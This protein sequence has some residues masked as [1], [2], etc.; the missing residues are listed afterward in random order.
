MKLSVRLAAGIALCAALA[1]VASCAKAPAGKW[2][3]GSWQ[4]KGEGL[5]GDIDVT[6]TVTGGRIASVTIDKQE[7]A[8]GVSD[9][10]L[11]RIPEEIVKAQSTKVDTV[12]GASMSS[13][14][15]IAAVEDALTKAVKQ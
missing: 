3:D 12:A 10:A 13:K 8:A 6:V 1:L 7:E 5:H 4:G 2:Q 15:I 11:Q 9:V 14:G